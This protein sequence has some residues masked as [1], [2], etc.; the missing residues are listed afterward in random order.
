M[1]AELKEAR[2]AAVL[3]IIGMVLLILLGAGL[4]LQNTGIV[5][6]GLFGHP[7]VFKSMVGLYCP[8]CG[9]TRALLSFI[10]GDILRSLFYH[11]FVPYVFVTGLIL[12]GWQT[13]HYITNKRIRE[14]PYQ[15]LY[16][17]IG[18]ALIAVS[19][20]AKN[21]YFTLTGNAPW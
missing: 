2:P 9:G 19:F 16:I 18:I 1:R 8:G 11:P 14:F 20:V 5:D 10:N 6:F 15:N 13:V 17:Y 4:V 7:C 21:L 3:Y 12:M